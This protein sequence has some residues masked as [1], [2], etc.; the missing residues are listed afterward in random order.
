MVFSF[1]AH[2]DY[3]QDNAGKLYYLDHSDVLK[4][5]TSYLPS[6]ASPISDAQAASIQSA[7]AAAAALLPNPVGF[8]LSLKTAL[9][10]IVQYNNFDKAY[11]ALDAALR[12]E[13]WSDVQALLIDAQTTGALTAAQYLA[14]K[15]SA[16]T[17]HLP[18]TLP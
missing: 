14:V 10:G 9:G 6:G 4:G 13:S 16:A 12:G 2:A 15:Q 18:I 11:T 7:A 3:F 5:W 17:Y 8:E 1:S